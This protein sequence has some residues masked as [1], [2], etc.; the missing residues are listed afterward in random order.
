MDT[1]QSRMFIS[2]SVEQCVNF[3]VDRIVFV[4]L[5]VEMGGYKHLNIPKPNNNDGVLNLYK[6]CMR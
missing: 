2:R 5:F 3:R 6:T 4:V 1:F